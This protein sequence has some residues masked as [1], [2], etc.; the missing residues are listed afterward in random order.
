MA[1]E[2]EVIQQYGNV[3][4]YLIFVTNGSIN[5]FDEET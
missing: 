4:D 5:L 2:G 3:L 1:K